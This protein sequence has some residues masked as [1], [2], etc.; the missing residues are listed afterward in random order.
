MLGIDPNMDQMTMLNV[1][2]IK[3]LRGLGGVD[4]LNAPKYRR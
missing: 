3:N 4:L 2:L 1:A